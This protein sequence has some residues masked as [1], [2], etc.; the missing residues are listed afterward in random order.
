MIYL[1][2]HARSLYTQFI[3]IESMSEL[4]NQN[5]PKT[6]YQFRLNTALEPLLEK[7]T[8]SYGKLGGHLTELKMDHRDGKLQ[9]PQLQKSLD[10]I[11]INGNLSFYFVL[12]PTVLGFK[13]NRCISV[14]MS[15]SWS[16]SIHGQWPR[17]WWCW[18]LDSGAH[19][20]QSSGAVVEYGGE[21]H[22]K[23]ISPVRHAFM[24]L[25]LWLQY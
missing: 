5:T 18:R 22:V 1:L 23:I 10:S 16:V 2:S 24:R 19:D 3:H 17:L 9:S 4:T 7:M 15:H 12:S 25:L 6:I 20:L 13:N 11:C 21:P 8:E 14:F